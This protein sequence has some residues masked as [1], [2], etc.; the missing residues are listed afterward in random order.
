MERSEKAGRKE[1]GERSMER[2][3]ERER[4]REIPSRGG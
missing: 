4:E 1:R 2:E 3:R